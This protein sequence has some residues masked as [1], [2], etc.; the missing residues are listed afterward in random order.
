MRQPR[1]LSL[2]EQQD[3]HEFLVSLIN[4][5]T[6][7]QSIQS[8]HLGFAACLDSDEEET[9]KSMTTM[10]E[11]PLMTPHPFQGLQ[12]TQLQCT[13]CQH[14]VSKYKFPSVV[15]CSRSFFVLESNKCF[16]FRDTF[17]NHS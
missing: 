8:R 1:W 6:S 11:S 9:S 14:K 17:L 4:L 5:L 3:S 13:E 12:V 10:S 7:V 2:F 16:A 15:L